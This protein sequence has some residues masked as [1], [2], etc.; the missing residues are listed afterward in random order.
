MKSVIT[1]AITAAFV[2]SGCATILN[3]DT[4]NI[5]VSSSNGKAIQGTIDGTPFNGP[6][7]VSVKR[8]DKDK[9]IFTSTT[10][11]A[12]QTALNKSVDTKF[13]IN[14]ISGGV[15]GSTTDFA[16]E[17]MWRYDESVVISCQ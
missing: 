5:N 1:L 13:F 9:V 6:G 11:C 12:N 15:F 17:D 10:G 8:E 3:E 4:Q 14:I 2:L 7:I 16:S